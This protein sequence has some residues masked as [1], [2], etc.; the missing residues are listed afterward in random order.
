MLVRTAPAITMPSRPVPPSTNP[1]LSALLAPQPRAPPPTG[2]LTG[3]AAARLLMPDRTVRSITLDEGTTAGTVAALLRREGNGGPTFAL[4]ESRNVIDER[5]L[6][7][8]DL[9]L[10]VVRQWV[11]NAPRFVWRD[12][13]HH[14]APVITKEAIRV[15]LV[16]GSA[17]VVNVD[18]ASRVRDVCTALVARL[19][20]EELVRP[21]DGPSYRLWEK[22]GN[23][24]VRSLLPED[25]VL[26][27]K[28]AWET[29]GRP[30]QFVFSKSSPPSYL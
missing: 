4:F 21:G 16:D 3:T 8:D 7:D 14:T 2:P 30:G 23:G 22:D 29:T 11:G 13:T 17:R 28:A 27:V 1:N 20:K 6:M 12:A 18:T 9:L 24:T 10:P 25:N 26:L 5:R 19:E 15:R